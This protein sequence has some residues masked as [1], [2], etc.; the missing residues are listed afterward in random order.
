MVTHKRKN[1][2][3]VDELVLICKSSLNTM[4]QANNKP[5]APVDPPPNYVDIA[6]KERARIEELIKSKGTRTDS[7]PRFNVAVRGQKVSALISLFCFISRFDNFDV[8]CDLEMG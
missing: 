3:I 5:A 1:K 2:R 7:Y 6:K 4:L 8:K